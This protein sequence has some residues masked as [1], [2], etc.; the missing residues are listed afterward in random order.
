MFK[1]TAR[2]LNEPSCTKMYAANS[3]QLSRETAVSRLFFFSCGVLYVF[4][5]EL[6]FLCSKWAQAVVCSALT[7]CLSINSANYKYNPCPV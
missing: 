1:S 2:Q 4:S 7:L 3:L 6:G 5:H